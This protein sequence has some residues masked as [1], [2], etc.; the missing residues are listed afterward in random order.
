MALGVLS[1]RFQFKRATKKEWE[2]SNIVL[3]DGELALESDTTKIKAGDGKTP[4]TELD[5]ITIGS[6]AFDELTEE[7]KKNLKGE[8]GD[9]FTYDDFTQKQL[10]QLKGEKGDALKFE[11]MT[12]EQIN[13]LR[14]PVVDDLTSGGSD[15]A[16]SAEQGKVLFNTI[17]KYH[18][19]K[20]MTAVIDQ[21]NSNPLT[22]ITYEDDAKM[23]EKGSPEWDDF[24]QSQ[25]VLFKDGKEVRELEDSELNNLKPEDGDVMVRF[26][27]KGLR[28]KT[29]GEKVYVSMTDNID[30]PDFKYYAH[31]RGNQRKYNFYL[32]AYLGYE[33]SGK[34]RSITGKAPTGAKTIGSF[35]TIAQANGT[36]YEQ[37]AFYQWTFLQAMYVLKY[38]NLDSQTAL[39]KGNT[40]GSDYDKATGETNGKGVDFGSTSNTT[41]VRFQWVE[42]FFG[43]KYQW[44]D[45]VNTN[46]NKIW[47]NN[48]NFNNTG[49]GYKSYEGYDVYEQNRI[50]SV[51]GDSERGF[52]P[53]SDNGS[54]ST[55]YCDYG[56]IEPAYNKITRVGGSAAFGAGAGAFYFSAIGSASFSDSSIGARLM[57]L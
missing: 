38:G 23:M 55:Y 25:L 20:V 51:I 13:M 34:L 41:K 53:K 22:C 52:I 8:K 31:T 33:E 10:N 35:R 7:D 50:K 12:E 30:D 27:R 17:L 54:S 21:A 32:G 14:A 29:V 18:Q 43:T 6:V 15:K 46:D 19:P 57:F 48:D 37:L 56:L 24:F 49:N 39:G 44:C 40:S 45:G 16:L 42:D 2:D 4:Y 47:I 28:I 9:P 1:G 11:D 5:Y 3:L 26:P 36:G